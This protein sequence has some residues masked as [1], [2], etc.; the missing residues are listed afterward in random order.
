MTEKQI[1]QRS[2]VGRFNGLLMLLAI[3][4]IGGFLVWVTINSETSQVEVVEG[5]DADESEL[6]EA[7]EVVAAET[8]AAG[9]DTYVDREIRVNDLEVAAAMGARAYWAELPPDG[10]LYLIKLDPPASEV[11]TATNG[12]RLSVTGRVL[13]M[14]DSVLDAW[15]EQGVIETEGQRQQAEFAITFIEASEATVTT[16]EGAGGPAAEEG[17]DPAAQGEEPDR[18]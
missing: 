14:G 7:L 17:E 11:V 18:E 16:G 9:P 10:A 3:L 5:A 8:F 4:T 2:P 15:T 6:G 13:A 12:D 1:Q